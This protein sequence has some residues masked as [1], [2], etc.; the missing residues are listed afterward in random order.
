MK[1]RILYFLA[2]CL[3]NASTLIAGERIDIQGPAGSGSFGEAVKV[4]PNGNFVVVDNT[5]DTPVPDGGAVYL[6]DGKTLALISRLHGS[7]FSDRVGNGGIAVLP[8]G[9]FL[10]RSPDWSNTAGAVSFCSKTTGCNGVVS[11]FNSLVG[12]MVNDR[13]GLFDPLILDN[14]NYVI[15]SKHWNANR[16]AV[17]LGNGTTGTVGRISQQNSLVGERQ[18]DRVG[19]ER[20]TLLSHGYYA[21][22]SPAWNLFRGA[23]TFCDSTVGCTGLVSAENSLVGTL[24]T[25]RV[26]NVNRYLESSIKDLGNGNFLVISSNWSNGSVFR[27]GAVT[28]LSAATGLR[29]VVSTSNSLVGPVE[30]ARLAKVTVLTNGNYVV[31]TDGGGTGAA[32]FGN[33]STGVFGVVSEANS[34]LGTSSG[35]NSGFYLGWVTPLVNGNYVVNAPT[36]TVNNF[37]GTHTFCNGTTGCIGQISESNSLIGTG[38]SQDAVTPLTNGNY[39]VE[40]TRAITFGNG[41]TGVS[42]RVTPENSLVSP[43]AGGLG[44]VVVPL[45]NGNYYVLN[46]SWEPAA[47][48]GTGNRGAVA[49]GN[50]QVGTV[51]TMSVANSMVNE[52]SGDV[53]E[54]Y[55]KL[56]PSGDL[57]LLNLRWNNYR[58]AVTFL[59]GTTP[60]TGT[61]SAQNSLV[62]TSQYDYVGGTVNVLANGKYVVVAYNW[63]GLRGAVRV[64][65][66]TQPTLGELNESNSF[67]GASPDDRVGGG[68][69]LTGIIEVGPNHFIVSSPNWNGDRGAATLVNSTTGLAGTLSPANSLVGSTAQDVISSGYRE[70]PVPIEGTI[71]NSDGTFMIF[72]PRLD[73]GQ[74][75]NAGAVT[76]TSTYGTLA[77]PV[78]TDHSFIGSPTDIGMTLRFDY[79]PVNRQVVVGRLLS[80]SVSIFRTAIA[81]P[82]VRISG[83]VRTPGGAVLRNTTV[84]LTDGSGFTRRATTSSF[85]IFAFDDVPAPRDYTI[86]VSSRRYRFAPHIVTN[87]S[88]NMDVG[89]IV[90]LE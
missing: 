11:E 51:G 18:S 44:L 25:D 33:G 65:S 86:T 88:A 38:G 81:L 56:L 41:T 90:G 40:S 68:N 46:S 63:G 74:S 13:V 77:G 82:P 17:T 66:G 2:W 8:S 87:A 84:T 15:N 72:S 50:G 67:V 14:G 57:L 54:F 58:G 24:E 73:S 36:A 70:A 71:R 48:P 62:G 23:V 12:S 22:E 49:F 45:P 39:V 79:D 6:Y 43:N 32:T 35:T 19:D 37:T 1:T 7:S 76:L 60:Q 27:A 80:K 29:G 89:N 53:G 69:N 61:I 75:V 59:S 64:C 34:L 31:L 3:L 20:I 10:V 55:W 52:R 26:G 21:V 9:D 47:A 28:W 30:N 83:T 78:T 4:L 16:G 5:A 42:G 85:G